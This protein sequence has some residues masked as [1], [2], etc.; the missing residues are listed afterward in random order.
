[1]NKKKTLEQKA[2][3]YALRICRLHK[4]LNG[5]S[6]MDA[7][8]AGYRAGKRDAKKARRGWKMRTST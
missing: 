4:A 3:D 5:F 1:M 8:F 2:L 6:L 7:W